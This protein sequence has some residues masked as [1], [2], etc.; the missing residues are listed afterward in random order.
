MSSKYCLS[1][2]GA[3][4]GTLSA[5]CP[6]VKPGGPIPFMYILG[7]QKTDSDAQANCAST[8]PVTQVQTFTKGA[9]PPS[10][11]PNDL[12]FYTYTSKVTGQPPLCLLPAPAG[13][14]GTVV[15]TLTNQGSGC[16]SNL[17][18]NYQSVTCAE[19][20]C[21]DHGS[22]S[23]GV[24]V[25]TDG[26]SGTQC[27]NP[28]AGN[29]GCTPGQSCG[30]QGSYGVCQASKS[31]KTGGI[32]GSGQCQCNLL[33]GQQGTFCEQACSPGDASAC[34]GPLRGTCVDSMYQ[35]YTNPNAVTNRCACVNG[36][37]GV[38]C[39][40]PPDNWKCNNTDKQCTNVT[41]EDPSLT[42]VTGVCTNGACV[43]NN[44]QPCD[45][46]SNTN[47]LGSA[48]TGTACQTPLSTS[49]S[50]CVN[51]S[52]CTSPSTCVGGAC[53]CPN[54]PTPDPSIDYVANMIKGLAS[55]ISTAK[56]LENFGTMIGITAVLP[57]L[58]K[59][60]AIKS[61]QAGFEKN[62]LQRL[63][64]GALGK[65]LGAD[66]A[67]V[68]ED[69]VGKRL[70]AKLLA[71]MTTKELI[72]TTAESASKMIAEM[73]LKETF[74]VVLGPIDSFVNMMGMLGMV[75]DG[76]DVMG[77]QEK[78]SQDQI[79]ATMAKYKGIINSD[80]TFLET[81]TAFPFV[82]HAQST[83]PFRQQTVTD[84]TKSQFLTDVSDY[85]S[86][87]TIN[88][89]GDAI[90]P[91]FQTP[92]QK[93][94]L[95]DLAAA[96]GSFLYTVAGKNLQVYQRLKDYWPVLV[97]GGLLLLGALIGSA[98]GIK[99]LLKNKKNLPSNK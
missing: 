12:T 9:C 26:W 3:G 73:A 81:G 34:G 5:S 25:C 64:D 70:A 90:I 65:T 91:L 1:V 74:G 18:V 68:L 27:Q 93:Q 92:S 24:C 52:D 95:Q 42:V 59:Y 79:T 41:T 8:D 63:E 56:G 47:S 14:Q 6:T 29:A 48:Y 10:A 28:P 87:L 32:T 89:N 37:S 58:L 16:T 4:V 46:S 23:S 7:P 99:A 51:P 69:A 66:G 38:T 20:G 57:K 35:F 60:F 2:D 33:T 67:K 53:T 31:P 50:P 94:D 85:L 40:I 43:C 97:A 83:F 30:N 55:M 62:I 13:I 88:S 44:T 78:S 96:Q 98:F 15:T 84:A 54:Q 36:W 11:N 22:C 21:G 17:F 80:K 72:E 71:K 76:F 77:L 19:T 61:V 39:N 86:H 49:G 82:I 45:T 75:L